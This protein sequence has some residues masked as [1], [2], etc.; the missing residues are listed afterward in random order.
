[1]KGSARASR[2]VLG[3][4]AGDIKNALSATPLNKVFGEGAEN[5]AAMSYHPSQSLGANSD[6]VK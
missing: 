5:D 3:A 1:M 6:P 4:L 2:A